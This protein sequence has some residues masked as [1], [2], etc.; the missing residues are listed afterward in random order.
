MWDACLGQKFKWRDLQ[1]IL[2]SEN[3]PCC[4]S[5]SS[6]YIRWFFLIGHP[7][8]KPNMVVVSHLLVTWSVSCSS[9]YYFHPTVAARDAIWRH[10]FSEYVWRESTQHKW[11]I[12]LVSCECIRREC[13]CWWMNQL[14]IYLNSCH[15]QM[16]ILGNPLRQRWKSVD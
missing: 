8:N 5:T 12:Y 2:L 3:L 7:P 6:R 4:P 14:D 9:L 15:Q 10:F 1:E 11:N 16:D 13:A